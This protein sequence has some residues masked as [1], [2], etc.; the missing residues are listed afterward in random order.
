[1]SSDNRALETN[2]AQQFVRIGFMQPEALHDWW[3]DPKPDITAY[4]LSLILPVLIYASFHSQSRR[5]LI[6]MDFTQ[7][8]NWDKIKRHF[9]S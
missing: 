3:Y 4:E 2:L 6:A 5:G 1:M 7:D 8:K 9:R